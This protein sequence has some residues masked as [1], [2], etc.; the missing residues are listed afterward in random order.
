MIESGR[1][2]AKINFNVY[3]SFTLV[4]GKAIPTYRIAGGIPNERT[5]KSQY[6]V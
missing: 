5:A 2:L 3:K 1:S 6:Q 4:R